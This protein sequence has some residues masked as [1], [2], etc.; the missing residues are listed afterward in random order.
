VGWSLDGSFL[1]HSFVILSTGV[2]WSFVRAWTSLISAWFFFFFWL[3]LGNRSS[4]AHLSNVVPE[5]VSQVSFEQY[6]A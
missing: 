1:C 4:S 3:V 6:L 5:N 2:A